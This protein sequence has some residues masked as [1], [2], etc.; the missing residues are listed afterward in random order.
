MSLVTDRT[1]QPYTVSGVHFTFLTDNNLPV[2]LMAAVIKVIS[3]PV[4][5]ENLTVP[6][7]SKRMK[8]EER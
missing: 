8:E 3:L 6:C 5:Q 1:V 7:L 2:Q 4:S